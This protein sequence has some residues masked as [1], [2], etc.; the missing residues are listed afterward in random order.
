MDETY[1]A[2]VMELEEDEFQAL[3]RQY[4]DIGDVLLD[5]PVVGEWQ[6]RSTADVDDVYDALDDTGY[7]GRK[8]DIR[9]GLALLHDIGALERHG[10]RYDAEAYTAETHDRVADAV[11][12]R[13]KAIARADGVKSASA[14][15]DELLAEMEE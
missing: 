12:E 1:T 2:A 11:R 9:N 5:Y 14:E 15:L 8:A 7:P 3:K 4:N 10:D 13:H 6:V